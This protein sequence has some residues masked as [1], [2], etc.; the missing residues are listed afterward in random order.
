V[1]TSIQQLLQKAQQT[2]DMLEQLIQ[3]QG[4]LLQAEQDKQATPGTTFKPGGIKRN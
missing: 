2:S 3:I 1:Y 4:A